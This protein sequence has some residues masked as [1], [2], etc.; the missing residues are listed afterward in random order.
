MKLS[1]KLKRK[2]SKEQMSGE[3]KSSRNG[4]RKEFTEGVKTVSPTSF[5]Y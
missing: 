1:R 5:S 2:T 4:V 3:L